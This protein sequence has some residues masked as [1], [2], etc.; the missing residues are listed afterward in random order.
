ME[1]FFYFTLV[2]REIYVFKIWQKWYA[3]W[4]QQDTHLIIGGYEFL[5]IKTLFDKLD[6]IEGK[7]FQKNN[8]QIM[9]K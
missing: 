3:H 9:R 2:H 7:V 4:M 6:D 1:Q 5:N 8:F